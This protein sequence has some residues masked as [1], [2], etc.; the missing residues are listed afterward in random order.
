MSDFTSPIT[1]VNNYLPNNKSFFNVQKLK[2][3]L[4][5]ITREN[6]QTASLLKFN[7]TK[8]EFVMLIGRLWEQYGKVHVGLDKLSSMLEE[9]IG[10]RLGDM[11]MK[12]L[13]KW[14]TETLGRRWRE[15][16]YGK[17]HYE[18]SG[19]GLAYYH[20]GRH[21]IEKMLPVISENVTSYTKNIYAEEEIKINAQA[22]DNFPVPKPIPKPVD[23]DS[24]KQIIISMIIT[25][26]PKT[27]K[28]T[29]VKWV[30]MYGAKAVEDI[31]KRA[32]LYSP[33]NL[34]AYMSVIFR[35]TP[36]VRVDVDR[37]TAIETFIPN[38]DEELAI[39]CARFKAIREASGLRRGH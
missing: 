6:I 39:G 5:N 10:K 38:S 29:V 30:N 23:I 11:Q 31:Y 16:H 33:D 20:I 25:A 37:V 35:D 9:R 18:L 14:F 15:S 8:H 22:V 4:S 27:R 19:I 13:S 1:Q 36:P 21:R 3:Q 26:S 12:R 7:K 17:Y 32:K 34:G 28:Q 24:A 2:D